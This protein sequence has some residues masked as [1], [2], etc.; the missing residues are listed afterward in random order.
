[1]NC[2]DVF[3][4]GLLNLFHVYFCKMIQYKT[5]HTWIDY[6]YDYDDD[7]ISIGLDCFH[8]FSNKQNRNK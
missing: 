3:W 1:M 5:K 7:A 4:N 2:D 8:S 6:Y